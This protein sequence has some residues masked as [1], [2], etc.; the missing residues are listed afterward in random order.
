MQ[1]QETRKHLPREWSPVNN[2]SS[3]HKRA[4]T[5]PH[6]TACLSGT[7]LLDNFCLSNLRAFWEYPALLTMDNRSK[8]L[9]PTE[10]HPALSVWSSL[11][12]RPRHR[13]LAKHAE[14]TLL[15]SAPILMDFH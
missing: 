15:R 11:S 5:E 2:T 6:S 13:E 3:S 12:L 9:I 4:S 10:F 8:A 7:A 14:S 1:P